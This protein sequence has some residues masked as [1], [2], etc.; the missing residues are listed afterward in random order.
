MF[1]NENPQKPTFPMAVFPPKIKEMLTNISEEKLFPIDYLAGVFLF[2]VSVLAGLGKKLT[3]PLGEFFA[4]IYLA[5]I[6]PQGEIK[7]PPLK[8][9]MKP[10]LDIDIAAIHE[11]TAELKEWNAAGGIN[12]G[13][14]KPKCQRLLLNDI[15]V[16][17]LVKKLSQNPLGLGLHLDE[18]TR[19]I[20]D[21]GRYTGSKNYD[22]LLSFFSNAPFSID[23]ATKDEILAVNTPYLSIIGGTQPERYLRTFSADK[24]DSGLFARF[25]PIVH[26]CYQPNYWPQGAEDMPS[27]AQNDYRSF[28]RKMYDSRG[29]EVEYSFADKAWDFISDWQHSHE[30]QLLQSGKDFEIAVYRK[31]QIYALKF[32]LILQILW[33]YEEGVE[34][35]RHLISFKTAALAVSLTEYFLDSSI[36]L[37]SAVN[38]EAILKPHE[39]TL[40]EKL[41]T[42]FTASEGEKIAGKSGMGRTAFYAFV[43]KCRGPLLEQYAWGKYRKIYTR[44]EADVSRKTAL[45]MN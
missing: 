42:V 41:P 12:S 6:G 44:K 40:L 16:E 2:I 27:G 17:A 13:R 38:P 15:T 28:I 34:A 9:A 7:S 37:A 20:D 24:F 26:Y 1:C 39:I 18:L 11:Y 23:R 31:M 35:N 43:K 3:T 19:L 45:I 33:D 30:T 22:H 32:C 10:I 21:T 14:P 25:L 29:E 36:D 8:W 4:N 5:L